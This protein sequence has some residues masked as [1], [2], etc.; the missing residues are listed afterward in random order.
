MLGWSCWGGIWSL[1]YRLAIYNSSQIEL[2]TVVVKTTKLAL[3]VGYEAGWYLWL[4]A[5]AGRN[6]KVPTRSHTGQCDLSYFSVFTW[7]QMLFPVFPH[8]VQPKWASEKCL[9]MLRKLDDWHQFFL[10]PVKTMA[11]RNP[12]HLALCWLGGKRGGRMV[13]VRQF[14]SF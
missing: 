10:F 13:E 8:E 9:R 2:P 6:T 1:V 5:I 11:Q 3:Q 14:L 12:T 4:G 7:P